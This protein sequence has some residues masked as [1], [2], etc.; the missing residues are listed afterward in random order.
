VGENKVEMENDILIAQSMDNVTSGTAQQSEIMRKHAKSIQGEKELT[1]H[2]PIDIIGGS[3][4]AIAG[5]EEEAVWNAAAQA[6]GTDRVHFVY[7]VDEGR[8]WYLAVPSSALAS[9]PDTWCPLAAALPGNSEYWDRESVYLYEQ[10]GVAAGIRWDPDTGRMQVYAGP[11]RIILPRLQSMD[12]N[13]LAI[14]ATKTEAVPWRNV[15]LH[16][17]N[18]SRQTVKWLFWSGLATGLVC[19]T[20]WIMTHLAVSMLRPNVSVLKEETIKSTERLMMEAAKL[21]RNDADRHF[22]RIQELLGELQ[23][24]GGTLV[25]Y[26]VKDNKTEWEALIPA[27]SGGSNLARLRAEA[28]GAETDGRI[29]I[30]GLN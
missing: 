4:P 5:H 2:L 16:A 19:L 12:A 28:V 9:N 13:F 24:L 26:E 29:K 23:S 17:E 18:L 30:Q 21:T 11:S 6:C 27:A 20:L 22:I 10:D 7:T 14:D 15:S 8:C 25:R 1:A 3:V